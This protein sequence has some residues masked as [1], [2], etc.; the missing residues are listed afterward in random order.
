VTSTGLPSDAA[1][2]AQPAYPD[3]DTARGSW[4]A[5]KIPAKKLD[6]RGWVTPQWSYFLDA[7]P[8]PLRKDQLVDLDQAFGFT[9]TPNAEVAARWFLLVIRAE[10]Q[11]SYPRLEEFLKTNGRR[12]LIL[13]LY[14]ELMKTPAGE[15][16]AKRVF[17]L[18]RPLYQAQ[19]AAAIEA[20]VKPGQDS[21]DD[22]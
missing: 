9:H 6:T 7:M 18:A 5:G 1:L 16:V 19:T 4:L 13:P 10:Y 22:E 8:T 3:V 17:P 15:A 2:A 12:S 21:S 20:I 14:G 11:P